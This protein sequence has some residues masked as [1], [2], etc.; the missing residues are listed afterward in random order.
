M[1]TMIGLVFGDIAFG[2]DGTLLSLAFLALMG[3]VAGVVVG[4]KLQSTPGQHT[5]KRHERGDSISTHDVFPIVGPEAS[6]YHST[7]HLTM[8]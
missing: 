5:S 7:H 3:I 8:H 2:M 6:A 4:W 1:E